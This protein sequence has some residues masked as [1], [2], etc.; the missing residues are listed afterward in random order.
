MPKKGF[1]AVRNFF[2]KIGSH[3]PKEKH[4]YP[5]FLLFLTTAL[6]LSEKADEKHLHSHIR[7]RLQTYSHIA[8]E[9]IAM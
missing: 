8:I 4:F 7:G 6:S 9:I 3:K 5:Q 1:C 2:R